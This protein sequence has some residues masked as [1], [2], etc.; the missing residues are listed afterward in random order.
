MTLVIKGFL[1]QLIESLDSKY[2]LSGSVIRPKS[3]LSMYRPVLSLS[4]P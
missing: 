1:A 2:V 3:T 4:V